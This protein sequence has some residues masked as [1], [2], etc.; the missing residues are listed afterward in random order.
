MK[1]ITYLFLAF[2]VMTFTSCTKETKDKP[3]ENG[4]NKATNQLNTGQ[5]ANDFLSAENYTRIEIEILYV[6]NYRLSS[7]TITNFKNF[8]AARLNKPEGI[9]VSEREVE[10]TG[11]APYSIDEIVNLENLYRS[12]YNNT[13]IVTLYVFCA[14]GKAETDTNNSFT[15]GTAYRNTSFVLYENTIQQNSGGLAQPSRVNLETTVLL[16]EFC[17]LLG[18]VNLGSPMVNAHQDTAHGKHCNNQ[19]CLMNWEVENEGAIN[20]LFGGS[21][22]ELDINC[23]NDLIANGGK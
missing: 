11:F 7:Q 9:I 3:I 19:D 14:D 21:I 8:I 16:H 2:F 15:L 23:L 10:P 22:P 13:N 20:M 12:K 4:I 5:S 17:H 6:K 18:L 1:Q